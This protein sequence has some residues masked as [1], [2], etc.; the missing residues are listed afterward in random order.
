MVWELDH[1]SGHSA[2]LPAG[3]TTK[4]TGTIIEGGLG[5]NHGGKKR[6]MRD[7]KLTAND[8]GTVHHAR[9]KGTDVT[10]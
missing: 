5:W 2:E 6:H 1:S 8:V 10:Q 3:L 9:F 4:Q 7:S